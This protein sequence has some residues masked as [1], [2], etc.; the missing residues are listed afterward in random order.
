MT[1]FTANMTA[2]QTNF[3]GN[4]TTTSNANFNDP[5]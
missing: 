4:Q 2:N 5:K 1:A 3:T